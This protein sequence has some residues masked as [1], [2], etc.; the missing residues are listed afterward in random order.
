M[1]TSKHISYTYINNSYLYNIL[2]AFR[3]NLENRQNISWRV[4][5][6]GTGLPPIQIKG[7]ARKR[8]AANHDLYAS[9]FFH[10]EDNQKLS[11]FSAIE[12][13]W[14]DIFPIVC[15]LIFGM[16]KEAYSHIILDDLTGQSSQIGWNSLLERPYNFTIL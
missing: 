4:W 10:T 11:F 5:T 16:W 6:S 8:R 14:F 2:Y 7:G 9:S 3:Y 13:F 12:A 1:N 15:T